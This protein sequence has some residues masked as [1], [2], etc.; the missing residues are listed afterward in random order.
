MFAAQHAE[1]I[2]SRRRRGSKAESPG[3]EAGHVLHVRAVNHR[4]AK[5]DG[6]ARSLARLPAWRPSGG[7]GI[8]L[9]VLAHGLTAG[10]S[11]NAYQAVFAWTIPFMALALVLALVM[12][13]KPLSEEMI[14]VAAGQAE[15]P[16]Y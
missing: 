2:A 15:V 5:P 10:H 6:H 11:V 7:E 4:A 9:S 1:V 12:R 3:P 13:E 8:A 16:E 14:E